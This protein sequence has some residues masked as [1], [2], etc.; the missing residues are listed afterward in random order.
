[1]APHAA[2]RA[3]LCRCHFGS[4]RRHDRR[5]PRTVDLADVVREAVLDAVSA[6]F[7]VRISLPTAM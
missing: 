2:R 3:R 6:G 1:M 4:H 7:A 5:C